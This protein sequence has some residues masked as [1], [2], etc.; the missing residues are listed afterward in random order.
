VHPL[1]VTIAETITVLF[2]E[3]SDPPQAPKASVPRAPPPTRSPLLKAA[4]GGNPRRADDGA[5]EREGVPMPS[6]KQ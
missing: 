2:G 6:I 5:Q 3:T 4:A 1:V